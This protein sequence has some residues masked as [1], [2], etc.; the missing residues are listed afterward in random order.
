MLVIHYIVS[1]TTVIVMDTTL[2][3]VAAY[4]LAYTNSGQ[5]IPIIRFKLNYTHKHIASCCQL[6]HHNI[7]LYALIK[8]CFSAL[9][10]T[11][12]TTRDFI[13]NYKR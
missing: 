10:G 12:F 11:D 6:L 8:L 5:R 9:M 3:K 1:A 4:A 2:E 7:A 13:A